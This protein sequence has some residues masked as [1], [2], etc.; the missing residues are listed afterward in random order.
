MNPDVIFKVYNDPEVQN[1]YQELIECSTYQTPIPVFWEKYCTF[2]E[3][4]Q[5]IFI[6]CGISLTWLDFH[7]KIKDKWTE[8]VGTILYNEIPNITIDEVNEILSGND[9]YVIKNTEF[10]KKVPT[11]FIS[12][13]NVEHYKHY[14]NHKKIFWDYEKYYK[15]RGLAIKD[16][17]W[18]EKFKDFKKIE[19][20]NFYK[21]TN[22]FVI[23]DSIMD[24][25][26]EAFLS[27][28]PKTFWPI[29]TNIIS[30]PEVR[31]DPSYPLIS[32]SDLLKIDYLCSFILDSNIEKKMLKKFS[33][34]Y[35][36]YTIDDIKKWRKQIEQ[37]NPRYK[38]ILEKI[39]RLK[40]T[41]N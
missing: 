38:S 25:L 29:M 6:E 37:S 18:K 14:K 39:D 33:E 8:I 31:E 36:K 1:H 27:S 9:K 20:K 21:Y 41:N 22:N 34:Q 16:E 5:E 17:Q 30:D 10:W 12:F 19:E 15:V 2:I 35:M 40:T 3:F 13:R 26:E 7:K 4:A 23:P 24:S 28:G 11:N 32:V